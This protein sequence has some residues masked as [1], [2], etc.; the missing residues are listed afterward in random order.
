MNDRK[1]D[2][3]P[4]AKEKKDGKP[5][6]DEDDRNEKK[7]KKEGKDKADK[8]ER[9]K[10]RR[11]K[12]KNESDDKADRDEK[13]NKEKKHKRRR[14]EQS[15]SCDE[16]EMA[17]INAGDSQCSQPPLDSQAQRNLMNTGLAQAASMSQRE[18]HGEWAP[19]SKQG[20]SSNAAPHAGASDPQLDGKSMAEFVK[21]LAGAQGVE[22]AEFVKQLVDPHE[23]LKKIMEMQ[24]R[25]MRDAQQSATD[26]K[27]AEEL[28]QAADG[29]RA[30]E[31]RALLSSMQNA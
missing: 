3:H 1:K 24:G 15:E 5:K 22:M 11:P 25:G 7:E 30:G 28:Q 16:T 31:K 8:D 21:Q 13:E 2:R 4:P 9:Q 17:T 14:A 29:Q 20:T 6:A 19:G 10:D 23:A 27:V 18:Q 12:E 26:H